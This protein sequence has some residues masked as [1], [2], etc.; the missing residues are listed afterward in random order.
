[1]RK[2]E[3]A[4]RTLT[5]IY[6]LG[7]TTQVPQD[8]FEELPAVEKTIR[9]RERYRSIGRHDGA[10]AFGFDY[11]GIRFSQETYHVFPADVSWNYTQNKR[12]PPFRPRPRDADGLTILAE[13]GNP[14]IRWSRSGNEA[15]DRQD[16]EIIGNQLQ[17]LENNAA[18]AI[19]GGGTPR[20]PLA[21][22]V[23][24]TDP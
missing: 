5:E 19:G 22:P 21:P 8:P 17:W 3:G 20:Q 13:L 2:I 6:L 14:E 15:A 12:I 11:N 10:E 9:I 1:V 16:L 23:S 18:N 7:P 24:V 4:S